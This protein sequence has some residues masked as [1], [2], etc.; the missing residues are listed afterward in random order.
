MPIWLPLGKPYLSPNDERERLVNRLY[1]TKTL[2]P[3]ARDPKMISIQQLK[4]I[5]EMV[6]AKNKTRQEADVK[7]AQQKKPY[8]SSELEQI[9]LGL[10]EFLAWRRRIK[11]Y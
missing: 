11:G 8:T 2:V 5:V 9:K 1:A 3:G 4:D 10:K 7:L 6:E